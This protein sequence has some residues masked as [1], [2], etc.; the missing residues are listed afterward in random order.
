MSPGDHDQI[1]QLFL[2]E[3]DGLGEPE[4]RRRLRPPVSQPTLWRVLNDLRSDGRIAV[5]G[6]ARATR[7]HAIERTDLP[8]LRSRRLHQRVAERL[9][10][11]PSLRTIARERLEKLRQVNPHGR[12]YNDRWAALLDGPLAALLRTLTEA[13]PQSDD[14]REE[15]PLTTTVDA[16]T[17]E[18]IFRSARAA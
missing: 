8:T 6:R 13:S 4:I 5:E 17:R 11:D 12:V 15:S 7:C 10:R 16:P 2:K 9:A 18:R 1:L 3:A 14:L